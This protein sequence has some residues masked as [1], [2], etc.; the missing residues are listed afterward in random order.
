MKLN[1]YHGFV[2]K[3]WLLIK[4]LVQN[5]KCKKFDSVQALINN[6]KFGT[7]NFY[8]VYS[9][10]VIFKDIVRLVFLIA[11][12]DIVHKLEIVCWSNR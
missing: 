1:V 10:K 7:T 5:D 3:G 6:C 12:Y 11:K 8:V 4:L 2:H 9:F